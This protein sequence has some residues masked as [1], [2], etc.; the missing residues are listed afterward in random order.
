MIVAYIDGYRARFGVEPICRVLTE[1]G[2][3]IAPSTYYA[4][5]KT[6][7]SAAELADAYL[8]DAVVDLYRVNRSVYGVRKLWREMRRAGHDVGRGSLST[9]LC[10]RAPVDLGSGRVALPRGSPR[11]RLGTALLG[12]VCG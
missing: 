11:R 10:K 9:F 2:M 5:V 3:Q 4:A 1:H 6:R 12:R 8:V 7:V